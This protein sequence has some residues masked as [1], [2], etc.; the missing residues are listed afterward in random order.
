MEGVRNLMA[1]PIILPLAAD[2]RAL[3]AEIRRALGK[4]YQLT[5]FGS[6]GFT[7]PLGKIK[8][9]LGEFDK[10]LEASNARVIAFGASAGAIYALSTALRHTVRATIEVQKSLTDINVIL[11][12]SEKRLAG[13]GSKLFDVASG[14]GQSFSA[15][16]NAATELS[17]QGL[18]AAETLK[19]TR[20]ALILTRLSG[21]DAASSVSALTAVM[22]GF[23]DVMLDSTSI[24]NKMAAVDAAFAVSSADLAEALKRVGSTA[25]TAGVGFD[26]LISVVTAAQ[27]VTARGGS[28]IGNSFKTIFT[29][30]QRPRV[31]T[32]LASLGIAVKDAAGDIRPLMSILQD[33]AKTYGFFTLLENTPTKKQEKLSNLTKTYSFFTFLEKSHPQTK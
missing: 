26:E 9:S 31:L 30:M 3:E 15:V 16:A 4:N 17:R 24:V 27:Q 19:R 1:R 21:L 32:V 12:L 23:N 7:Q 10:S 5:G 11:G 33:L 20:D 28:V 8:G 25:N 22:N 2:T 14:T 18:G 6:R 29:R 13:F